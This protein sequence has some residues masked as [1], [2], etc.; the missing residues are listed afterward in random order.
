MKIIEAH[1]GDLEVENNPG[2]RTTFRVVIPDTAAPTHEAAA[3]KEK[4]RTA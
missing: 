1:E 2:K 4:G 3:G